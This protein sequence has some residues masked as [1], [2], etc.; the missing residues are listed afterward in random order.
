MQKQQKDHGAWPSPITTR[1]IVEG[2][3]G[4]G[5]ACG[6]RGKTYWLEAR[7]QEAGRNVLV[8]DDDGEHRDINPAPYNIRTRVHE[9]GG[10]AWLLHDEDCYFVNFADQQVYRQSLAGG[11]P[12]PLTDVPGIRFA[13]GCVDV[14]RNRLVY[15]VEDHNGG[16]EPTN[17]LGAVSLESGEVTILAEGHDFYSS[18]VVS[19]DGATLAFMTWD[20]PDMPWDETT[21][22]KLDLNAT[23]S[24]VKVAGGEINGRKIAAQQPRFSPDGTLYY[25]SDESDWWNLYR[26]DEKGSIL[27]MDAEFG[28]PH[29]VFGMHSYDFL[30]ADRLVCAYATDNISHLVVVNL[31][32]G[33]SQNIDTGYENIGG[34][35]LDGDRLVTVT[36]S[37][38]AFPFVLGIDL[39]STTATVVKS[40]ASLDVDP[41][42]LSVPET[43]SF[44]TANDETAHAFYYPPTNKDFEGPE[45]QLP[46]L[47]VMI[48]GGPTTAT[49]AV[50]NL[51]TQYWTTRGFGVLDVNYRGSSGYGRTYR[52]KLLQSWG[53]VDV[54]DAVHGSQYLVDEGKVDENKLAIRGGSAGGY[55]TLAALTF[56]DHFKAGASHYGIGDLE[57]LAKDTHKF[58]SRYLDSMIGAYPAE[59]ERYKARSPI[60]HVEQLASPCIFFQ[61]LEDEVVPPNQAEMMVAALASKGVPTAYVPFEGEQHGFRRAENIERALQLELF[62]YSRIF[63]FEPADKID[64][65][66]I[67]NLDP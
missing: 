43:I 40:S 57:A 1:L 34:I 58:E 6:Y 4:I 65:V 38:T 9:Y 5:G 36:A 45:G 19:P 48:H 47:V 3:I 46:P 66:P 28:G 52:D 59:I 27:P 33:T 23:E 29:W 42:Y 56:T 22:W 61:G 26:T 41:D 37:A 64:P 53:I 20:H 54:E 24:P 25:I 49:L 17:K 18:P 39:A 15:V 32:E 30:D 11:E 14:S 63:N 31:A 16:G 7:P 51:R 10:D 44:P 67:T 12:T 21:I 35:S 13:N 2:S 62:F 55:T 50:L 60:N 8:V